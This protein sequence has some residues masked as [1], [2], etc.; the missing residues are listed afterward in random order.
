MATLLG[1]FNRAL[2]ELG[3]KRLASVD[4]TTPAATDCR[5]AWAIVRPEL[6]AEHPWNFA[7]AYTTLSRT[8]ETPAWRY[9]Y[10]YNLPADLISLDE[11]DLEEVAWEQV[12]GGQLYS[13]EAG[14][15]RIAYTKDVTDPSRYSAGFTSAAA[16]RLALE[17][18]E[19]ITQSNTKKAD[20]AAAYEVRLK[21]AI[22]QDGKQNPRLEQR[23]G[24]WVRARLI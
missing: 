16:W 1:I 10:V 17:L 7:K 18:C 8:T 21:K 9:A 19:K 13:D 5:D 12:A 14:P 6:L 20:V 23:A 22:I 2:S 15:I 4:D 3:A 24:R 11:V